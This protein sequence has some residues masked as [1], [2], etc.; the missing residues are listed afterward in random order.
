LP[1]RYDWLKDEMSNFKAISKLPIVLRFL[2]GKIK[3]PDDITKCTLCPNMCRNACPVGIVDGRETT[4]PSGKSKIGFLLRENILEKNPEN[5]YPIYACL[6]CGCCERYC[7]FDFSV[8]EIL[9]PMKTDLVKKGLANDEFKKTLNNLEKYGYPYGQLKTN[10]PIKPPKKNNGKC[11]LYLSGCGFR[12]YHPEVISKT[13]NLFA[14][15]GFDVSTI[16]NEKC[17]GIPAYNIGDM[18]TFKTLAKN[19][20][21]IINELKPDLIVTSCPSCVYSYKVLYPKNGLEINTPLVH[22]TEF[23]NE[24]ISSLKMIQ[25]KK[26]VITYHNP[27]KLVNGLKQHEIFSDLLEKINKVNVKKPWR[28]GENTFCCGYGGSS[29]CRINPELSNEIALERLRELSDCSNNI[30]TACPS[31]KLAF[32]NAKRTI[33]K[34][35]NILDIAELMNLLQ[36]KET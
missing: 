21:K 16:P 36:N 34:E 17:C 26:I 22:I 14:N 35:I 20:T 25:E 5:V 28:N 12:E 32:E 18:K 1:G 13:L 23:L 6:S 2:K 30:I 15:L 3:G 31:C 11:I 24:N 8:S 10:E 7:P 19:N 33:D 29:I 27:C 4:S 9:H